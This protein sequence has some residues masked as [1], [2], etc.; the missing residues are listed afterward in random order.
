MSVKPVTEFEL[1]QNQFQHELLSSVLFSVKRVEP[2]ALKL[3]LY[4]V[5]IIRMRSSWK[6]IMPVTWSVRSVDLLSVTG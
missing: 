3:L 1:L 5:L 6:I 2:S 4:P